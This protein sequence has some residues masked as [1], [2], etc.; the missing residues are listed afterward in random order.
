VKQS[1]PTQ[2]AKSAVLSPVP[3][4]GSAWRRID[5]HLHSPAI[6]AFAPLKGRKGEDVKDVA[7]AYVQ[8]LATQ[9]ISIAAITDHNGVNAEWFEVIAAKA[10]NRGITL[11]P[12]VELSLREGQDGLHLLVVFP[13][14]ADLRAVNALVRSL[15]KDP[16]TPFID[17]Q[18]A[19]RNID[20]KVSLTEALK[21]LR[22]R[23][24]CLL[25]LPHPVSAK[26]LFGSFPPEAAARLLVE[27]GPDAIEDFPGEEK[28]RL[29]SAGA[30]A[31]D[32]WDHLARVEFSNPKRIEEIGTKHRADGTLRATYLKLGGTTLAAL[33]LALRDPSARLSIGRIPSAVHPKIRTLTVS[34]SGFLRD[35]SISWNEDLSVIIG[36]KGTGKSSIL[37]CLRYALAL[38]PWPGQPG[39]EDLLRHALGNN[40]KVEV[41]FERS[42]QEGE[43]LQYRIVRAWG[44]GPRVLQLGHEKEIPISSGDLL[45]PDRGIAIFGQREI[46]ALSSSE[47]S[48]LAFFDEMMG[49]EARKHADDLI[50]TMDL[51]AA[52]GRAM[53][54]LEE[55]LAKGEQYRQQIKKIDDEMEACKRQALQAQKEVADLRSLKE[56]LQHATK[57]LRDAT[58]DCDRWRRQLLDS[59]EAVQRNLRAPQSGDFPLRQEASTVLA[60]LQESLKVVLYD[61]GTLF[62]QAALG[63]SRLDG[64]C[65]EK[66]RPLTE[67]NKGIERGTQGKTEVDDRLQRL[68]GERS[69]LAPL[70]AEVKKIEDRLKKLWEERQELL[71]KV[72]DCRSN[73]WRL[74]TKRAGLIGESLNGRLRLRIEPRGQKRDYQEQLSL[75]LKGSNLSR[76]EIDRLVAPGETDGMA[77]AEAARAGSKEVQARFGLKP[78]ASDRLTLWLTAEKS[79]LLHLEMILPQDALRLEMRSGGQYRPLDPLSTKQWAGAA[80]LL[81]FGLEGRILVI[82]QPEDYFDDP[83]LHEEMA[84]VLR[85]QKG[86]S[87]HTA[88]RQVI[89]A[90]HDAS[91][92]VLGDAELVLPL[93]MQNDCARLMGRASIDD[94]RIRE[95]MKETLEG[96]Q[97]ALRQGA[98]K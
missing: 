92:P 12:G 61:E 45:H 85:E 14:D 80:L 74:R 82:D 10:I 68:A 34:G 18:G 87:S 88:R 15:D 49:E 23:S 7:E 62:E 83:S 54:D 30:L 71:R 36:G 2:R 24:D 35:L 79:R 55:K 43:V 72:R 59:L 40:G 25:I 86:L 58:E 52:N 29:Q 37:E 76:D 90:T 51:L 73:Q 53:L 81:L 5:L 64:R 66:L 9:A 77:L 27:I 78:E 38:P 26:G 3:G 93:E 13:G 48:R 98:E 60:V 33:R 75:L 95:W 1:S 42:N 57:A 56:S 22:Q 31:A 21:D 46:E 6:P 28:M 20:L 63:F 32:F 70:V 11:L 16:A 91:L 67:E 44:E 47:E 97:E 8:Q 65:Q 89:L 39:R 41:I 19:H 4:D 96:G 50:K 69:S 84:Q 17:R 94:R